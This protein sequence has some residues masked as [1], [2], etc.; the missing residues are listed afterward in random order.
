MRHPE[1]RDES[2]RALIT[3]GRRVS[4]SFT[5]R[6]I[7]ISTEH[8]RLYLLQFIEK[9]CFGLTSHRSCTRTRSQHGLVPHLWEERQRDQHQCPHRFRLPEF[10][11]RARLQP[12]RSF[13]F[14][15]KPPRNELLSTVLCPEGV[16]PAC[17]FHD[18]VPREPSKEI[19][20]A[21]PS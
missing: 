15:E 6:G 20:D 4:W 3:F 18:S 12:R 16:G 21:D 5:N 10:R 7:S 8:S 2:A 13:V 11:R 14:P 1:G 17:R 19:L 9:F